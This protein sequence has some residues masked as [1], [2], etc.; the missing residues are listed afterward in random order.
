MICQTGP[1]PTLNPQAL[2]TR[3]VRDRSAVMLF[4]GTVCGSS[5]SEGGSSSLSTISFLKNTG[6]ARC[7]WCALGF[8]NAYVLAVRGVERG[9]EAMGGG[10]VGRCTLGGSL[11]FCTLGETAK[12]RVVAR[13]VATTDVAGP[14]FGASSTSDAGCST[15]S[16]SS[17]GGTCFELLGGLSGSYSLPLVPSSSTWSAVLTS[18]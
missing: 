14:C 13:Q 7:R 6:I 9:G 1:T 3:S 2:L 18:A 5:K 10:R 4:V 16:P 15:T 17:L 11:R 8:G 12:L